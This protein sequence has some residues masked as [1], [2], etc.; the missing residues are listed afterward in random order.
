MIKNVKKHIYVFGLDTT[1]LF[2]DLFKVIVAM[3]TKQ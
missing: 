3:A 1:S 2:S